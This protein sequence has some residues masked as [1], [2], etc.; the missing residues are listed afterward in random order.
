MNRNLLSVAARRRGRFPHEPRWLLGLLLLTTVPLGLTCLPLTAGP[1]TGPVSGWPAVFALGSVLLYGALARHLFFAGPARPRGWGLP[2]LVL[3]CFPGGWL[4]PVVSR[5]VWDQVTRWVPLETV[6]QLDPLSF[7]QRMR[8][9]ME[10]QQMPDFSPERISHGVL[11]L[12]LV[13]ILAIGLPE[14]LG[15]WLCSFARRTVS[16]RERCGLAFLAGVGFG[17]AEGLNYSLNHYNGQAGLLIYLMRFV[18]LVMFHGML[19][20]LTAHW[21]SGHRPSGDRWTDVGRLLLRLAPTV[22]VHGLYDLAAEGGYDVTAYL[23]VLLVLNRFWVLCVRDHFPS[24]GGGRVPPAL[25]APGVT[26]TSEAAP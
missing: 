22:V 13:L 19:S 15:K 26:L 7:L 4:V 17:V 18:S 10:Q 12:A 9:A 5:W 24:P 1:F 21:L 2:A 23:L 8:E 16:R 6:V 14:E 20:A 11:P 25:P 3:G